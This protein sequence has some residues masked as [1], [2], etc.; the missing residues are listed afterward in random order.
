MSADSSFGWY[1]TT[2]IQATLRPTCI[3]LHIFEFDTELTI[4]LS[5]Y[6]VLGRG[7]T[8]K[9]NMLFHIQY[10]SFVSLIVVKIIKLGRRCTRIA[11]LELLDI[12]LFSKCCFS[13]T[14]NYLLKLCAATERI[15]YIR[16][17]LHKESN[18]CSGKCWSRG[19]VW[20]NITTLHLYP[21]AR[22]DLQIRIC[23]WIAA[24]LS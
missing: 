8:Q 7:C 5:E 13:P 9:W 16:I 3:S 22:L 18:C 6:K 17:L 1:W 21:S 11:L 4:C 23:H 19:Q 2:V 12:L 20:W 10:T 14:L 24:Q 15:H